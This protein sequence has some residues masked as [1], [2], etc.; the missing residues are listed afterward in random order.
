VSAADPENLDRLERWAAK[1]VE[2]SSRLDPNLSEEELAERQ[3]AWYA[4]YFTPPAGWVVA[5]PD[6]P[7]MREWLLDEEGLSPELADAVLIQMRQLA[8]A[9]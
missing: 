2:E 7:A 4:E 1:V 8:A 5:S 6:D 3:A 9:R